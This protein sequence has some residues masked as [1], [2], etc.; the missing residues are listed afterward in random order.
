MT[1]HYTQKMR[2]VMEKPAWQALS[3]TAQALYPW[4]K[5]EWRGP[6]NSNNGP[7]R[8]SVR[9]AAARLGVGPDTAYHAFHDLQRKGFLVATEAARLGLEGAAKG[10]CY[11]I[12]EIMLPH[13]C[14]AQIQE[15][16]M[17]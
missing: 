12:I 17:S 4:L 2:N 9:Q 7:I 10:A 15:G 6:D 16:F 14:V 8:L 1:E 3:T 11:E 13:G 5:L